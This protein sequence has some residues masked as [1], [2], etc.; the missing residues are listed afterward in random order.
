MT[1]QLW[2]SFLQNAGVAMV[3]LVAI[4][5]AMWRFFAWFGKRLDDWLLPVVKK[6]LE[7][8]TLLESHLGEMQS[9]LEQQTTSMSQQTLVMEKMLLRLERLERIQNAE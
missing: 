6:H 3:M 4:G 5:M 1:E 7:F 2:L 9:R 8:V